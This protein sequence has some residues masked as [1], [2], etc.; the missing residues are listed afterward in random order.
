MNISHGGV[1]GGAEVEPGG[2]ALL[3]RRDNV[4]LAR[5]LVEHVPREKTGVSKTPYKMRTL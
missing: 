3:R 4:L 2:S 5:L 1:D